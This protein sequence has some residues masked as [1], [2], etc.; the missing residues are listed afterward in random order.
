MTEKTL[1]E[2]TRERAQKAFDLAQDRAIRLQDEIVNALRSRVASCYHVEPYTQVNA[3]GVA[4]RGVSVKRHQCDWFE[5]RIRLNVNS[6]S[7]WSTTPHYCVEAVGSRHTRNGRSYEPLYGQNK[8]GYYNFVRMSE[9]VERAYEA[10]R[11]ER[12]RRERTHLNHTMSRAT[13]LKVCKATGLQPAY[14]AA[15]YGSLRV[16]PFEV[17]LMAGDYHDG[18]VRLKVSLT[19]QGCDERRAL[20]LIQMLQRSF[21]E[22]R[23]PEEVFNG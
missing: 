23:D 10:G 13:F 1:A 20:Q 17:E 9:D 12:E 22:R 14:E 19:Q 3:Q 4:Y 8:D 7:R 6:S 16:G 18:N 2:V 15:N 5:Y 21:G 11:I